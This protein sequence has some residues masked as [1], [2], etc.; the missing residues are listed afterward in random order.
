MLSF[1][2]RFEC[3]LKLLE[4]TLCMMDQLITSSKAQPPF[5][6]AYTFIYAPADAEPAKQYLTM[7][8]Q[9]MLINS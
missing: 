2:Y 4:A 1:I 5:I 6:K 3:A 7:H 9:Y 8:S